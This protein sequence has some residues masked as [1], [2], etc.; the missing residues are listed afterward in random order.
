[1]QGSVQDGKLWHFYESNIFQIMSVYNIFI[2]CAIIKRQLC[3]TFSL[4]LG[5]MA[6]TNELHMNY[7]H[8]NNNIGNKIPPHPTQ[9]IIS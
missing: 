8:E 4:A 7:A 5:L 1:M 6:L 2:V 9:N 3:E